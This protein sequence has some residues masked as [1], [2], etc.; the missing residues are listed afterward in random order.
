MDYRQIFAD[1]KKGLEPGVHLFYGQEE[2]IKEQALNQAMDTLIGS[3]FRDFNHQII[4]GSNE[5]IE[6]IINACETLPFMSSKRVIVVKDF[7]LLDGKK[8]N[9]ME[10]DRI[11]EYLNTIPDTTCLIFY[12]RGDV[13]KRKKFYK[14]IKENGRIWDFPHLKGQELYRWIQQTVEKQGNSISNQALHYFADRAGNNLEDIY[15]ELQKLFSYIGDGKDI[16]IPSIDQVV[17]PTLEYSIFKLVDAI[18]D[19]KSNNALI[20]L[21][22]LLYE[23]QAI[24]PILAMIARQF[25]LILQSKEHNQK[26]DSPNRIAESLK[27][28]PFVIRK[29]LAQGRNFTIHQ[30]KKGIELCLEVDYGIKNGKVQ[31]VLG[32]ELL[33][34]KMC[35]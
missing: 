16:D 31:D 14:S 2:Y 24:Q 12:I 34:I 22:E 18:G 30:L 8:D 25:R 19:K 4:D 11:I 35:Q 28:R 9:E 10:E 1:I 23:G 7:S 20:A 15:N 6:V 29:C 32:L 26:G 5:D 27:Q 17:T 13:D 21:S 33:I 3:D